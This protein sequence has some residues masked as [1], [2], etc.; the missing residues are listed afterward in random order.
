MSP[1]PGHDTPSTETHN[2]LRAESPDREIG[3]ADVVLRLFFQIAISR[4]V[5]SLENSQTRVLRRN[6]I[7]Y[8]YIHYIEDSLKESTSI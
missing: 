1:L 7:I 4:S 3:K 2:V 6:V 8:R 5:K